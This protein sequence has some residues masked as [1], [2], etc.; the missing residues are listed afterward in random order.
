MSEISHSLGNSIVPKKSNTFELANVF[1]YAEVIR[2]T[3][4]NLNYI[5]NMSYRRHRKHWV[6][7]VDWVF[8]SVHLLTDRSASIPLM[9]EFPI[10]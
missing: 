10:R 7:L 3:L 6:G 8:L 5:V 4:L 2:V 1:R 9:L